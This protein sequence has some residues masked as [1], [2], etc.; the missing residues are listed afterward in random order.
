MT[1]R[2]RKNPIINNKFLEALHFL[3]LVTKDQGSPSET[4]ITLANH[5]ATVFNGIIAAG[6][7]IDEELFA[8][9]H[10]TSLINALSKCGQNY[11]ITQFDQNRLQIKSDKFKA[12]IPCLDIK[13][14]QN[15][16]PD[17]PITPIN[18]DFK[19][20]IES[21]GILANENAQNVV[22]ASILMNGQSAIASDRTIMFEYWHGINLPIIVLPKSIVA[23]LTKTTKKLHSFGMSNNSCTFHF[24]DGSYIKTQLFAEQWP[25]VSRILDIEAKPFP[26]PADF[27]TALDAVTPFSSDGILYSRDGTLCSGAAEGNGATFECAGLPGGLTLSA[28][29]MK[30]L[31][32]WA[33]TIDWFH[34]NGIAAFGSKMRGIVARR[35]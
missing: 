10:N 32:P 35:S 23:P 6:T 16:I 1:K 22:A 13:L 31:Q 28:K 3:S 30:L 24:E 12:F 21:V 33:T 34:A 9:P 5:Q 27:W 8:C 15:T 26:F 25:N 29:H 20:A 2:P 17:A 18:D 14:L 11:S 4:H 19:I 7:P